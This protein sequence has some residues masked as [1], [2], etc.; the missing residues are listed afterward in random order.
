MTASQVAT[1]TRWSDGHLRAFFP[2]SW[3]LADDLV[4]QIKVGWR[5]RAIQWL[6]NGQGKREIIIRNSE[7]LFASCK[8]PGQL[9]SLPDYYYPPDAVFYHFS[10][11]YICVNERRAA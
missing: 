2:Q 10:K 5:S 8:I 7:G 6:I 9:V 3:N 1:D 11:T 4:T